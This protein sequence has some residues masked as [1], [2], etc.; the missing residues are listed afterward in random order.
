ML[1]LF[2]NEKENVLF[3]FLF[4]FYWSKQKHILRDFLLFHIQGLRMAKHP[5]RFAKGERETER[6]RER[7]TDRERQRERERERER[8]GGILSPACKL[9]LIIELTRK[10]C[11]D[12]PL[13]ETFAS[14]KKIRCTGLGCQKICWMIKL[15]VSRQKPTATRI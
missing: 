15:K 13:Y 6:D 10:G 4:F 9:R 8:E 12:Q 1:I 14:Q 3:W 7:E 2:M 5:P 11:S